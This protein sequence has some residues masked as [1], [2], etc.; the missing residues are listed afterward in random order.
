MITSCINIGI[1]K[2]NSKLDD[3]KIWQ[4]IKHMLKFIKN[5]KTIENKENFELY[6]RD[7]VP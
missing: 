4:Y 2:I 3:S 1:T 5:I 7:S 6:V